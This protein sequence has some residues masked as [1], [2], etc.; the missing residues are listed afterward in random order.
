M[1]VPIHIDAGEGVTL[2]E[3]V[4]TGTIAKVCAVP[5]PQALDGVTVTLPELAAADKL[6]DTEFAP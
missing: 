5:L 3:G 1:P 2:T 4:A 6:T